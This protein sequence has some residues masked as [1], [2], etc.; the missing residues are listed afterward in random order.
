MAIGMMRCGQSSTTVAKELK[1]S[2][3]VVW[4]WWCRWKAE[5][6]VEKKNGSG[7]PR[8][9]SKRTDAR[10]VLA[11]KRN[12]FVSVPKLIVYWKV[13]GNVAC[14]VRTAYR[15]LREAG[16]QSRRPAV[17]IPLSLEHRRRRVT[18]CQGHQSWSDSQWERVL[19]TDESRFTLDFNDGRIRVHRLPSERFAPCC[20]KEHDRYGGG[21]VMVWAGIWHNGKTPAIVVKGTLTGQRYADEIVT[22]V[23]VPAVTSNQLIFQDDNARPHR[24]SVVSNR[25]ASSGIPTLEWPSRSP[26]LSPIE[27][28]WDELGRRVRERYNHPPVSLKMLADR[29]I[30]QWNLLDLAFIQRLCSSMPSR[31]DACL[32]ARGG[33]TR[34]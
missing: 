2:R 27:H 15:R 25:I 22:P 30:E 4:R 9:S 13:A 29:L 16:I 1:I 32:D 7:R 21:S 31:I 10:L 24:A 19:W 6:N 12:R 5:G 26:D 11:A 3:V 14:S 28:C 17:R 33:H 20:V 8:V 18:W 34:F 23:V